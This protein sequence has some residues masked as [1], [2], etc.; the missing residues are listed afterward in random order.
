M[1]GFRAAAITSS[2]FSVSVGS[3]HPLCFHFELPLQ[4]PH[5]IYAVAGS[6]AEASSENSLYVMKMSS[7]HRTRYDDA[8]DEGAIPLLSP[9]RGRGKV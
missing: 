6:Q 9:M 5:T 3:I 7:L 8:S 4:Y 1:L 2:F